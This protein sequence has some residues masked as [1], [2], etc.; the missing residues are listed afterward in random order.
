MGRVMKRR[1]Y[2]MTGDYPRVYGAFGDGSA[3]AY[4]QAN[5]LKIEG[6]SYLALQVAVREARNKTGQNPLIARQQLVH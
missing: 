1:Y 6:G 5:A 2:I 3:E 4:A